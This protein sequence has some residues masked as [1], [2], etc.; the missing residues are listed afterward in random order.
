[1]FAPLTQQV[2]PQTPA[3]HKKNNGFFLPQKDAIIFRH[4]ITNPMSIGKITRCLLGYAFI[5]EKSVVI[6]NF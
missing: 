4:R 3:L 5:F 1:C 2:L 6:Y